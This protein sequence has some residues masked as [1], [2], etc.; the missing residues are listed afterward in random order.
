MLVRGQG[1]FG[2]DAGKA[3][4]AE[5]PNLVAAR[6][7]RQRLERAASGVARRRR[8]FARG[9]RTNLGS[10]LAA[11]VTEEPR[12][13]IDAGGHAR[14]RFDAGDLIAREKQAAAGG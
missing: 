2:T 13:S 5:A 9:F 1:R 4:V 12:F 6:L 7:A 8:A 14:C 10:R 11:I 3:G